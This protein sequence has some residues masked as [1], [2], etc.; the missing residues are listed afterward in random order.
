MDYLL[1]DSL[2]AEVAYGRFA[3]HR[4]IENLRILRMSLDGDPGSRE[5]QLGVTEGGLQY[6]EALLLAR[7]FM[8]TQVYLHGVRRIYDLH[9]GEL[10]KEYLEEGVFSAELEDYLATTDVEKF[11][12]LYEKP[13]EIAANLATKLLRGS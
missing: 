2:H 10:L 3:H 1:R 9:L 11:W 6:A 7:Y 5:P 13:R 4:L 12:P 8:F